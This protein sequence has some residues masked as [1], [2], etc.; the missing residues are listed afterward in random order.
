MCNNLSHTPLSLPPLVPHISLSTPFTTFLFTTLLHAL[1]H[2]LLL[3][4]LQF[5]N[6]DTQDVK[7]RLF[8]AVVP[9][10]DDFID[11]VQVKEAARETDSEEQGG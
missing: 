5:F 11:V 10:K 1:P 4:R 8:R 3:P 7:A 9:I 6:V 2:S